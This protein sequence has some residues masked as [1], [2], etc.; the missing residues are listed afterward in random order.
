MRDYLNEGDAEAAC[1][2]LQ[3]SFD[4]LTRY[5]ASLSYSAAVALGVSNPALDELGKTAKTFDE[6]E[7]LLKRSLEALGEKA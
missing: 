5:Y 1:R 4:F 6:I 3:E 2:V 7:E